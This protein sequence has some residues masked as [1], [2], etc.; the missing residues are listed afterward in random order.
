MIPYPDEVLG[1]P[2]SAFWDAYGDSIILPLLAWLAVPLGVLFVVGVV[3]VAALMVHTSPMSVHKAHE[4]IRRYELA[5]MRAQ[6]D[7]AEKEQGE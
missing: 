5:R 2:L 1:P 3:G 6:R 7:K 4:E